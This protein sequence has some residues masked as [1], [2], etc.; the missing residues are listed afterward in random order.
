MARLSSF[1]YTKT[2]III[3]LIAKLVASLNSNTK[4]GAV[5]AA[6]AWAFM[7]GLM[8]LGSITWILIFFLT[9][10]LRIN[11]GFELLFILIFSGV[12]MLMT[13]LVDSLGWALL[14]WAPLTAAVSALYG[15]PLGPFF[16]LHNSLTM[17]GLAWGLIFWFPLFFGGR[18]LVVLWREKVAPRIARSKA[19]Q[20]L[21]KM[22]LISLFFKALSQYSR[23][24]G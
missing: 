3:K 6:I 20:S 24:Q 11:W 5:A 23:L 4:P 15:I 19:V 10:I 21:K 2:M 22:P 12:G 14:N 1:F 8:P 18:V 7:L 17:G 16:Q 9:L 13:G